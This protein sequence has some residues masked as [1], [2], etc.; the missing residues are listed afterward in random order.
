MKRIVFL[1][2]LTL[3]ALVAACQQGP[4]TTPTPTPGANKPNVVIV[5]PASNATVQTGDAVNIQSTSVDTEG[6][7][8]V[9]LIVDGTTV[10]NSPTPNGQP[11]QQFSVIQTWTASTPGTH[12]L[13]VRATNARLGTGEASITINVA[14]R[15]AQATQTLVVNPTQVITTATA[16]PGSA[17]PNI[18]TQPTPSGPTTCTLASQFISDITIPDGTV[19]APGGSFVKTWAIRNSGTCAWG[20]GYNAVFVAGQPLGASSPQPIPAAG[21]G[22]TINISINMVAPTTPG[23]S[24]S[25]WQLQ[26]SNGVVFGTRFDAVIVVPGAPTV[27]PP[28]PVPPTAIPPSGCNGTPAF[29]S[30]TANPPTISPGQLTT[31]NWGIVNNANAVYLTSPSGTQ[32][33][34][35]PGSVQVQPSQTTTYTLTAYCNNVPAQLQVTVTVSGGGGTCN[36]T[37]VF[38]GF[39]ANPQTIN[40]GQETTLNWGL[41][42]NASSVFLQLPNKSEPVGTPGSRVVKPTVTTTYSLVA[43]CGNNQASVSLTV[44]VNGGCSGTPKFNGFGANPSTITKGQ[45]SVLSWGPVTNATAVVLKGP[46]GSGGVGTPGQL[47]VQPQTTTTYTLIAYC[48]NTQAQLSVTVTVNSPQPTRTP[49]NLPNNQVASIKAQ[50]NGPQQ[51]RV[52]VNYFWNGQDRPAKIQVVGINK[53]DKIVTN[54]ATAEAVAGASR[55]V[56]LNVNVHGNRT[57]VQFQAC[58]VGK[59]GTELVCRTLNLP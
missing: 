55:N 18:P 14:Q 7:V 43:R 2:S 57:V 58:I 20:G 38:N 29:T 50:P 1:I 47:P 26:A 17:T 40:A 31:L 30:F 59:S 51:Y 41:V 27:R 9:E 11:Q 37:P 5:S 54:T 19:I 22:D 32:G 42:Q 36:G 48:F 8:L 13:T 10:Q 3:V 28:T 25:V 12:T 45:T 53:D 33:V 34:G 39:F 52:T 44:N 56:Q 24:S 35:T 23:N 49:T 4:S 16:I 15:I 6:V 46:Q 21:P